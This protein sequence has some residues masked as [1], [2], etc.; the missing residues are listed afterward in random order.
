MRSLIKPNNLEIPVKTI[1]SETELGQIFNQI[2]LDNASRISLKQV[3]DAAIEIDTCLKEALTD[4]LYDLLRKK[5]QYKQHYNKCG[6]TLRELQDM[7][8]DQKQ[9][10]A[11]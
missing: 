9:S 3:F 8:C 7:K 11:G 5:K 4:G 1:V 6:E 10:R 2:E